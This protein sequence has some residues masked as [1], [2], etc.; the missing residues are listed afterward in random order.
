MRASMRALL[1]LVACAASGCTT[2]SMAKLAE[3]KPGARPIVVTTGGVDRPY[4]SLGLVQI[5]RAGT[6]FGWISVPTDVELEPV[7]NDYLV[8]EAERRGADAVIHLRFRETNYSPAFRTF[9]CFPLWI[10]VPLH[11]SVT[12]SG[13]LVKFTDRTAPP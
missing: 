3:T 9:M 7:I 5:Y 10:W 11:I 8:P 12:V 2:V 1:L 13:E 4:Q 6:A